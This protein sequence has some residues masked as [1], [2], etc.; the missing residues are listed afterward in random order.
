MPP[1]MHLI[2]DEHY[3][4]KLSAKKYKTSKI[5]REVR[6][7][8]ITFSQDTWAYPILAVTQ[9]SGIE[10]LYTTVS[11]WLVVCLAKRS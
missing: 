2:Y 8:E 6:K 7:N 9:L 4:L 5:R 1:G 3:S 10:S 11:V